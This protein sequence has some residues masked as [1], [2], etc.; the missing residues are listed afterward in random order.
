GDGTGTK[1]AGLAGTPT[2]G[3]WARFDWPSYNTTQGATYPAVCSLTTGGRHL[4]IGP[5]NGGIGWFQVLD[6]GNNFAAAAGTPTAGGWG[7]LDWP[8]YN[9]ASG[10]VY[11][12]CVDA[13]GDGRDELL[14]GLGP[15]A[16]GSGG[17]LRLF[18]DLSAGLAA[19]NPWV[20][21]D[22]TTYNASGGPT[23]PAK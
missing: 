11:P 13:D 5:G 12:A 16:A 8:A 19:I 9:A 18:D 15:T 23:R 1:F 4:V 3:G 20:R 14:V 22:W 7:R 17:Y 10:S 2:A 6:A 21:V